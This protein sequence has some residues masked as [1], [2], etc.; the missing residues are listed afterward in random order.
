MR[1]G[2]TLLELIL[3]LAILGSAFAILARISETGTDAALEAKA[4]AV[5]RLACQSRMSELLLDIES[6]ITPVAVFDAPLASNDSGMSTPLTHTVEISQGSMQGLMRMRVTVHVGGV[7]SSRANYSLDRMYIDPL[8]DL[9]GLEA[10][11]LEAR[12]AAS[13][14]ES[15]AAL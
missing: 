8:L 11:E 4:L 12:E 13:S 3:A 15:G 9:V 5:A 6:G 1:T 14:E 2:I 10:A 7:E